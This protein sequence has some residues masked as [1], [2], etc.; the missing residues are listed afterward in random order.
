MDQVTIATIVEGYGEVV[1]LP[2][3]L[4]N[5]RP[6]WHYP[7]PVRAK[8]NQIVLLNHPKNLEHYLSIAAANIESPYG[9]ILVLIDADDDCPATLGPELLYHA[10][11]KM[12][13]ILIQVVL[14]K[15]E[16][17]SWIIAGRAVPNGPVVESTDGLPNPKGWVKRYVPRY[18]EPI[19][20]PSLTA[21]MDLCA[22]SRASDSFAKL[23]R[24]LRWFDDQWS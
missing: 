20:Q 16:F 1:A 21:R 19:D 11:A 24:C 12:S 13:H 4:R 8:R 14:A 18:S 9:G 10:N 15:R 5:L 23:E 22:A 2:L 7:R 6:E 3:L 17:E